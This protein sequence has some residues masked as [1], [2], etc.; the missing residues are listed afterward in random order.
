MRILNNIDKAFVCIN[1]TNT[2]TMESSADGV[3]AFKLK[4]VYL[5][6]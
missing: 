6:H 5:Y 3:L 2:I 4:K 1:L